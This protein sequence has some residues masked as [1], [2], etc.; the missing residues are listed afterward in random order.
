MA[1][2]FPKKLRKIDF[3]K[4]CGVSSATVER[5]IKSGDLLLDSSNCFH[6]DEQKNHDFYTKNVSGSLSKVIKSKITK[7]RNTIFAKKTDSKDEP[8]EPKRQVLPSQNKTIKT[9]DDLEKEKLEAD[10]ELKHI[11][12][13][14]ERGELI[15]KKGFAR[16]I[17]GYLDMLNKDMLRIPLQSIDSILALA[18]TE[19]PREKIL[20]ILN[21][22]ISLNLNSVRTEM[23]ARF[24]SK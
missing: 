18:D 11:K 10:I 13:S 5:L 22:A 16:A 20:D 8:I 15:D 6:L 7:P 4:I 23:V 24:S 1:G 14:K 3:I 17:M 2:K 12:I 19:R 21:R 9:R